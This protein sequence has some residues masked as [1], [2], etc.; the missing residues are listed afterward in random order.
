M[1]TADQTPSMPPLPEGIRTSV[2]DLPQIK[3]GQVWCRACG[4]TQK[5]DGM[6][7]I[8]SGWPRHCG[9][10]MTLDSP[11]ERASLAEPKGKP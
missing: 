4:H 11:E 9:Y 5:A 1:S 6:Q 8:T 7:A 3:R 2:S 10:T